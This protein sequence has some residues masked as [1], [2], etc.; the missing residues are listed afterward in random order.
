MTTPSVGRIVH[1]MAHGTPILDDGS[2][3]FPSVCRAAF[4][5]ETGPTDAVSL[6]VAN[7]TGVFFGRWIEHDEDD[8]VGGTWHWPEFVQ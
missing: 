2:Q 3:A 4:V 6:M 8:K 1:Y 7:P 5:T